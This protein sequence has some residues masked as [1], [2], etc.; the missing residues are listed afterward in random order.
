MES[1]HPHW[2]QAKK[3][4]ATVPHRHTPDPARSLRLTM[5]MGADEHSGATRER[6]TGTNARPSL[7]G[8]DGYYHA[9]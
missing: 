6:A 1:N 9:G 7:A 2:N 3:C 5:S 8:S 4:K